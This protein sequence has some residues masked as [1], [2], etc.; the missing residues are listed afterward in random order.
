M[1]SIGLLEK[2][3]EQGRTQ[4]SIGAGKLT[5]QV[6]LITGAGRKRGI[7]R[8]TALRLAADGADIAVAAPW[9]DPATFPAH[10]RSENWRGIAS[11][12]DEIRA[13]GR[14][15]VAIECDVTSSTEVEAMIARIIAE[16]G[17]ITGVVNCAGVASDAGAAPIVDMDDALWHHTIAVNLTGV[18]L[19]SKFAARAMLKAKRGGA[20]VNLSSLAGRVGMPNYGAYCATKFGVIGLTQQMAR[21]LA[22]QEIRVNC[23][24]PGSTDTDMMDGTFGRTA[25]V[26]GK[27]FAQIKAQVGNYIPMG[28]QGLPLEQANAIAFL[29]GPD[30]S[31]ITGQT[32]N[33]DGGVRMD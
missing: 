13:F 25:K 16:L 17:A 11:L 7:G 18:Y 29:I 12:A 5:G 24:C 10:E 27:E 23:V 9:R 3:M 19:V 31:Y 6:V 4:Q 20:I 32:L 26:T 33:V 14:R 2:C 30:A 22:A 28:R 15:A 21:E 8:A 1:D